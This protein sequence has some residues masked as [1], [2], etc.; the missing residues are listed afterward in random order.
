MLPG[1]AD[2]AEDLDA[3]LRVVESRLRRDRGSGLGRY[4]CFVTAD[5]RVGGD[6]CIPDGSTRLLGRD[7][8]VGACMLDR[9]E[10]ADRIAELFAHLRVLDRRAQTPVG[11]AG[12]FRSEQQGTGRV[13]IDVV[14]VGTTLERQLD[15]VDR[16]CR[17]APREVEAVQRRD[18]NFVGCQQPPVSTPLDDSGREQPL[19]VLGA[20]DGVKCT[21][22]DDAVCPRPT[23]QLARP[24]RDS[25]VSCG[26]RSTTFY[27]ARS[28]TLAAAEQRVEERGRQEWT[29]EHRSARLLHEHAEL[30]QA[31]AGP[32]LGV[33]RSPRGDRVLG[34]LDRRADDLAG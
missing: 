5:V 12:R 26:A 29:R 23:G 1:E 6:R 13:D 22:E 8:H 15:V 28:T 7:Q 25:A 14:K 20:H 33:G 30:E 4:Q 21:A 11:D 16:D 2:A 27:G 18:G 17:H 9:L 31:E 3:A 34:A 10:V 19:G 24:P 32:D